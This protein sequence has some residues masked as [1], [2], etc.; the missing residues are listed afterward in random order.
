[1]RGERVR[2]AVNFAASVAVAVG[3]FAAIAGFP[4]ACAA[5]SPEPQ[6]Y[7]YA[8]RPGAAVESRVL[9]DGKETAIRFAADS[10]QRQLAILRALRA[11]VTGPNASSLGASRIV[12]R[13][14]L[15][16]G[17]KTADP[18]LPGGEK[19]TYRDFTLL[20]WQVMAP[21]REYVRPAKDPAE[22]AYDQQP[23]TIVKNEL[24]KDDFTPVPEL[25]DLD[26]SK[27]VK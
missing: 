26:L 17:E 11:Q 10:D 14:I 2:N 22:A 18:A 5:S 15:R 20:E 3:M 23:G 25:V 24:S 13:G 16:P 7:P 6:V 12:V 8:I 4:G 19:E 27:F 9:A 21:F 1:M